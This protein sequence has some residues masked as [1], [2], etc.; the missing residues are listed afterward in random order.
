MV[1]ESSGSGARL[2]VKEIV[3]EIIIPAGVAGPDPMVM[4]VR[5]YVVAQPGGI[6]VI[7]TG[8][9]DAE[10]GIAEAVEA[11][12]G[13]FADVRDIILTHLHMDHVGS[14]FAIA[15]H[16]PLAEIYAGGPDS[17][18]IRAPRRVQGL[19]EGDYVQDLQ[20]FATPGHTP[21]HVSVFHEGSG[22]LFVGDA[23]VSA[24]GG[25]E[26]SPE[27]FTSDAARAEESLERLAALDPERML[28]SHG[29]E[30]ASPVQSL[31]RLLGGPY[32]S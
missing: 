15:E 17:P 10:S 18:D 4:D 29:A 5:C 19:G 13:T 28:F 3:R 14:L 26:R 27:A 20:I 11:L 9:P 16:A 30:I 25:V 24:D 21:G 12:G 8:M 2:P 31:A 6:V 32:G 1:Q 23:A 22:T 7:D